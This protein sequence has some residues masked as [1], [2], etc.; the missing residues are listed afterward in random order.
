MGYA[1]SYAGSKGLNLSSDATECWDNPIAA[2]SHCT[3]TE[4]DIQGYL[5]RYARDEDITDVWIWSVDLGNGSYQI[6]IDY[7]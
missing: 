4:R 3:N 1:Q 7:D 2:G 6:Y 5:N